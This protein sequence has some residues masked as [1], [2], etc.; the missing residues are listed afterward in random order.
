MHCALRAD[1][2]VKPP[3]IQ[4]TEKVVFH[5]ERGFFNDL[6]RFLKKSL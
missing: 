5:S 6:K 3:S 2:F 4:C 1:I